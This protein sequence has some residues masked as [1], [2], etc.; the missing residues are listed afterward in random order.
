MSRVKNE[1]VMMSYKEVTAKFL[2]V[3]CLVVEP[4]TPIAKPKGSIEAYIYIIKPLIAVKY[5]NPRMPPSFPS[6][7][8][9][10]SIGIGDLKDNSS[11]RKIREILLGSAGVGRHPGLSNRC[12]FL[13]A[14]QQ[15]GK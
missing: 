5:N 1:G 13:L 11:H 2:S 3:V 14:N 12:T 7:L 4:S 6:S 15:A 10:S 9:F 8:F